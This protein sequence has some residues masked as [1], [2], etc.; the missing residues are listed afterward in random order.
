MADD[1]GV[2]A[3]R[4]FLLKEVPF[5]GDGDFSV[6]AF[7]AR[8]NAELA[9]ALGNLLNRV[10]TLVEKN[11]VGRLAAGTGDLVPEDARPWIAEV[12][13]GYNRLA[14]HDVLEKID[15]LYG[16]FAERHPIHSKTLSPTTNMKTILHAS[17]LKYGSTNIY[18]VV[19]NL[20]FA[21]SRE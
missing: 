2:D 18:Y 10:L 14:F 4:Y 19:G 20:L 5:G 1:F 9:N 6:K 15:E 8:Y 21:I 13:D 7:Q 11:F 3:F 17:H 16:T 12:G